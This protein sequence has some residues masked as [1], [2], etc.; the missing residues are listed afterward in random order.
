MIEIP[1]YQ[2]LVDLLPEY[3]K[4]I[5]EYPEIMKAW[6]EGLSMAGGSEQQVWNNLYIQ[7]CDEATIEQYE[8]LLNLQPAPGDPLEVRRDRVMSR[9]LISTPYSERRLRAMFNEMF[10]EDNYQ[11][12]VDSVNQTA[13]MVFTAHVNDGVAQFCSTWYSM[14]PAQMAFTV[15]EDIHTD[16]DGNMFY[17]GCMSQTIYTRI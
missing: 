2:E 8:N 7:T 12:T 10:G 11:L 3:F 9:L 14:A 13:A 5:I 1:N 6:A 16:I 4:E 17:G 15:N